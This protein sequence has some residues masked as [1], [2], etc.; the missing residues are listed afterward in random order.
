MEGTRRATDVQMEGR[1]LSAF[2]NRAAGSAI[3]SNHHAEPL[4]EASTQPLR[5]TLR[6][7]F[8][9]TGLTSANHIP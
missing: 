4:L 9:G 1:G 2:F 6:G 3:S 7:P 5:D 8:A